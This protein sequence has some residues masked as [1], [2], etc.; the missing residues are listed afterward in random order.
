MTSLNNTADEKSPLWLIAAPWIFVMIWSAGYA[1]AKMALD[2]TTPLNLLA[3][4]FLG[5]AAILA[6]FFLLIRPRLPHW[7]VLRDLVLISLFLQIGHFGLVYTGMAL[8]A[9]AGVVALFAASQPV[10]I[11][12]SSTFYLR[13][14]PGLSIWIGLLLGLGGAAWVIWFKGSFSGGV[15]LGSVLGFGAVVGLSI[16]AVIEKVRKPECHPLVAYMTQYLFASLI[17]APIAF[18]IE[19]VNWSMELPFLGS[20]AYITIGNSLIGIYIYLSMV[21]HGSIQRVTSIM[22]L[23]PGIAAIMAWFALDETMP[24]I[25]MPGIVIAAVGVLLVIRQKQ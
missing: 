20:L 19:G 14:W 1:A 23:V 25:A 7:T 11:A 3:F 13:Q 17:S 10:L 24:I 9:S 2:Y 18:T 16:G 5:A 12:I 8:G 4:R 22:F 15:L 21:R 6:P